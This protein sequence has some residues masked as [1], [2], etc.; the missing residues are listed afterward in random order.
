MREII[1][2]T[3]TGSFTVFE[4]QWLEPANIDRLISAPELGALVLLEILDAI[5]DGIAQL[6]QLRS[7]L[8]AAVQGALNMINKV[9]GLA[10]TVMSE[11]AATQNL[12]NDAWN[13]A[14]NTLTNLHT[15]FKSDPASEEIQNKIS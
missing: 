10:D 6:Q 4:T 7:D 13:E 12:I 11:L 8:Y 9:A 3:E 14:K 15:V 2:P 5:S 1:D